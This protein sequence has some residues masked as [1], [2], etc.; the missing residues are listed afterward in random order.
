MR[1]STKLG[2]NIGPFFVHSRTQLVH[3]IIMGWK[4]IKNPYN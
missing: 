4:P 2:L 3:N 1:I